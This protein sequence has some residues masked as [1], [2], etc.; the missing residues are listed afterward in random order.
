MFEIAYQRYFF[1]F[2]IFSVCFTTKDFKR[3]NSFLEPFAKS[4]GPY[5]KSTTKQKART[6]NKT[7]QKSPRS[8]AMVDRLTCSNERVNVAASRST[9]SPQSVLW[10]DKSLFG[11]HSLL[12]AAN[13][14]RVGEVYLP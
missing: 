7:S 9:S 12:A 8:N 4:R 14:S 1:G 5:S 3:A 10:R 6:M 13:P 11:R 2:W